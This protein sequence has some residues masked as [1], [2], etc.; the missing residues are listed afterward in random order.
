MESLVFPVK[1]EDA[2]AYFY[3]EIDASALVWRFEPEP[4]LRGDF[5]VFIGWIQGKAGSREMLHK[6]A[7]WC[8][9]PGFSG[10]VYVSCS[11]VVTTWG[12]SWVEAEGGAID[13]DG[14]RRY[15]T[16]AVGSQFLE[17]VKRIHQRRQKAALRAQAA[18]AAAL[19]A[20]EVLRER[21]QAAEA[22][23]H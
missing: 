21:V 12:T 2:V 17:L 22:A 6:C 4:W 5:C 20:P 9:M 13:A 3:G 15:F 11:P 18:P 1:N 19:E 16:T 14:D 8:F 23:A 10:F 7:S